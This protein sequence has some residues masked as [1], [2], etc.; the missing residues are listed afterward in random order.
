MPKYHVE[1]TINFVECFDLKCKTAAL[2][3]IFRKKILS[4]I[5]W[6]KFV[7]RISFWERF[8]IALLAGL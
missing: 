5:Y 8:H 2:D 3:K 1:W 4:K 7:E 6:V